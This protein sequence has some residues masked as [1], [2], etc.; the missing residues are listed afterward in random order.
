MR[1]FIH[2][3][4]HVHGPPI[5]FWIISISLYPTALN[6]RMVTP[7]VCNG[8]QGL[9]PCNTASE[10]NNL[11]CL[12]LIT[13]YTFLTLTYALIVSPWLNHVQLQNINNYQA[14]CLKKR[15]VSY[16]PPIASL[17]PSL[18]EPPQDVNDSQ[19]EHTTTTDSVSPRQPYLLPRKMVGQTLL[20]EI[21]EHFHP[22]WWDNGFLRRDIALHLCSK[23]ASWNGSTRVTDPTLGCIERWP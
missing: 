22:T 17:F 16:Q 15:P 18:L 23:G 11:S 14:A 19:S 21:Q 13:Y 12:L 1:I 4:M 7:G 5:F 6:Y 20:G 2:R 10:F 8:S 3:N 9:K